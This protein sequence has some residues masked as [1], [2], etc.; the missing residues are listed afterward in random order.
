MA[1]I[2][3]RHVCGNREQEERVR[4]REEECCKVKE[5]MKRVGRKIDEWRLQ[6]ISHRGEV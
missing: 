5:E 2:A 4:E 6:R 3:G 1:P